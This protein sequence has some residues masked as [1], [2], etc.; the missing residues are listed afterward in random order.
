[1]E[2]RNDNGNFIYT[3][4]AKEQDEIRQIRQKYQHPE[5]DGMS[6][7]RKLDA[8]V[9]QKATMVSL[10]QG[11]VGVLI[12]GSGMS[13]VM[14]EFGALVGLTGITGMIV[15]IGIGLVGMVMVGFAYPVYHI[16]L[17]KEREKIAPEVLRLTEILLK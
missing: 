15:G 7:L 3:Y 9:S 2:T 8:E 14:T 13:L 12:M 6:R 5:E 16:V 4:S 1:M 17:K 10:I 11:I